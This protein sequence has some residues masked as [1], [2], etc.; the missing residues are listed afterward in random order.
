MALSYAPDPDLF[1]R[2]GG[3]MRISNFLLWQVAYSE[4]FFTDCLWPEFGERRARRGA[5][6]STRAATAASAPS[7]RSSSREPTPG[8]TPEHA[9]S[10]ESITAVVLLAVL[11]PALFVATLWPFAL[12]T[13]IGDGAAGWEWARLNGRRRAGRR[14]RPRRSCVALRC[15]ACYAGWAMAAPRCS[16]GGSLSRSGCSAA[17]GCCAPAPPAGRACRARCA[18]RSGCV[19]L[20][21]PGSRSPTPRRSAST[22]CCRSSCLVWVADIAAYFGGRAL[23][24]AQARAG[25][26]PGQELGGRLER[27]GGRLLARRPPGW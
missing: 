27:H 19:A 18:G 2:T 15:C 26:Q 8:R 20:W 7:S 24:P 9:A 6:R 16:P 22:S 5:R 10:S 23:R 1:I 3:E 11:L 17:R 12:L 21:R 14:A 25:D 4:L 13:L